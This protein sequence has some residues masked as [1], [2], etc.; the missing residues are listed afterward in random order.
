MN[1]RE[2]HKERRGRVE[3]GSESVTGA[4]PK[5]RRMDRED[6]RRMLVAGDLRR[7]VFWSVDYR[8]L[9]IHTLV[10]DRTQGPAGCDPRTDELSGRLT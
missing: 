4:D 5:K 10:G 1:T 3:K 8:S 7:E 6:I 9:I 2:I